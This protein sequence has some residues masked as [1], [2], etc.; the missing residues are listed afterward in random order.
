MHLNQTFTRS[1]V[2]YIT[3]HLYIDQHIQQNELCGPMPPHNNPSPHS[4]L[5]ILGA[6]GAMRMV[7]RELDLD[8]LTAALFD[9]I[10]SRNPVFLPGMVDALGS[11][12]LPT[13]PLTFDQARFGEAVNAG[14]DS[15]RAHEVGMLLRGLL[16]VHCLPF[17]LDYDRLAVHVN[18]CI[19]QGMATKDLVST[20]LFFQQLEHPP[21]ALCMETVGV[22]VSNAAPSMSGSD[23][24]RALRCLGTL[25]VAVKQGGQ[26]GI[27][28][29]Q[30][31]RV[32]T[33]RMEMMEVRVLLGVEEGVVVVCCCHVVYNHHKQSS[34]C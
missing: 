25:R 17:T 15:L 29:E 10:E 30:L 28:T 19:A 3:V 5:Q 8:A 4:T 33:Q 14:I 11:L 27:D 24:M 13:L 23:L 31:G 20:L 18:T 21:D 16:R 12:N 7:P 9:H 26:H 6:Y 1:V 34:Y 2:V 32:L 22:A